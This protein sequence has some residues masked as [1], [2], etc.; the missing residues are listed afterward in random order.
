[1][2]QTPELD[3]MIER[4]DGVRANATLLSGHLQSDTPNSWLPKDP[5]VIEF[6]IL[7]DL[8]LMS[9]SLNTAI[10]FAIVA[11]RREGLTWEQ[12]GEKLE[13]SRQGAQK[14][15]AAAV[16]RLARGAGK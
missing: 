9:W 4:L 3:A 7:A 8:A 2:T 16:K 5:D 15:H 12:I 13:M 10:D 14:H 1:M 11:A 6:D